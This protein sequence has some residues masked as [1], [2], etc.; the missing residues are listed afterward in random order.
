MLKDWPLNS[1]I[2]CLA[3]LMICSICVRTSDDEE[4]R[5]RSI[6]AVQA[7]SCS[8]LSHG[9]SL[10]IAVDSQ[11]AYQRGRKIGC[12]IE[13]L[14]GLGIRLSPGNKLVFVRIVIGYGAAAAIGHL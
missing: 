3:T 8:V 11:S 7:L 1:R 14:Q 5:I 13:H 2:A 12:R 9:T 4:S 10:S 6:S